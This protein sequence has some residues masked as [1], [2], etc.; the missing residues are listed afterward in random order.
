MSMCNKYTWT[1]LRRYPTE[2]IKYYANPPSSN[3][4]DK[5]VHIKLH[6]YDLYTDAIVKFP[7]GSNK[8]L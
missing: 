4:L 2:I 5:D 8:F 1:L 3:L 6:V 7:I